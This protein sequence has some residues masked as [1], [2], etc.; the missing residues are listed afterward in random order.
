MRTCPRASLLEAE[1]K[2]RVPATA[3]PEWV[4]EKGAERRQNT[5]TGGRLMGFYGR[6]SPVAASACRHGF[7]GETREIAQPM[8]LEGW[9]ASWLVVRAGLS[10]L[11][12]R[13]EQ[14]GGCASARSPNERRLIRARLVSWGW[15]DGATSCLP[16]IKC[17]PRVGVKICLAGCSSQ[18]P[19]ALMV[20]PH[21]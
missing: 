15:P 6:S 2:L 16:A 19:P 8:E 4:Q 9:A 21:C 14:Q 12:F 11:L 7:L 20:F 1:M 3:R 13:E 17:P 5:S 18:P 10:L